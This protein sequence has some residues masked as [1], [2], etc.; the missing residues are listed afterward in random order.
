MDSIGVS[1]FTLRYISYC[2]YDGTL[3]E[4]F[5]EAATPTH[6][7]ETAQ[8]CLMFLSRRVEDLSYLYEEA[9]LET[10]R[11]GLSDAVPTAEASQEVFDSVTIENDA[12][13][14][15]LEKDLAYALRFLK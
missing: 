15:A 4:C 12:L 13:R 10:L 1:G 11:K 6:T 14:E 7:D 3:R 8:A 2:G 5:R 9:G